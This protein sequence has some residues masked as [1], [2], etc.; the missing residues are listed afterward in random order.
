M[1]SERSPAQEQERSLRALEF[2]MHGPSFRGLSDETADSHE[3][4]QEIYIGKGVIER[5][6]DPQLL[7]NSKRSGSDV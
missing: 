5:R 3:S 6:C 4:V 2:W 1:E 7:N